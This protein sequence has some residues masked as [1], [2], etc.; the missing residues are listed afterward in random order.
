MLFTQVM[1]MMIPLVPRSMVMKFFLEPY[2]ALC[3]D[4]AIGVRTVS[5]FITDNFHFTL[6]KIYNNYY[7]KVFSPTLFK[8]CAMRFGTLCKIAGTET[9]ELSLV[10]L[11][12]IENIFLI[13]WCLKSR[14]PEWPAIHFFVNLFTMFSNCKINVTCHYFF[15]N[16]RLKKKYESN[17]NLLTCMF[18]SR[19]ITIMPYN[20]VMF[21]ERLSEIPM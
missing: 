17:F 18:Y 13:Q 16:T 15:M 5:C 6:R 20:K 3:S 4:V 7:N 1:S 2:I 11:S 10:S 14:H 19:H 12:I 21:S 9:T 8:V